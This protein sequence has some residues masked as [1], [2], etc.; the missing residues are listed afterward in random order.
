M[1]CFTKGRWV[2][3]GSAFLICVYINFADDW[4]ILQ[5]QPPNEKN[6][7]TRTQKLM[8]GGRFGKV[9]KQFDSLSEHLNCS[10]LNGYFLYP[11]FKWNLFFSPWVFAM[12]WSY[13]KKTNIFKLSAKNTG[14]AASKS[15]LP[16]SRNQ[17][18]KTTSAFTLMFGSWEAKFDSKQMSE[19]GDLFLDSCSRSLLCVFSYCKRL[20]RI[21]GDSR[22]RQVQ[23]NMWKL[24]EFL[25]IY[26]N[27]LRLNLYI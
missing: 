25:F 22:W 10:L 6:G 16:N 17:T 1:K 5:K 26:F 19:W 12:T 27:L 18:V 7:S 2:T 9:W 24:G 20:T 3:V 23:A 11:A 8:P 21:R 13:L 4:L 14:C 15:K